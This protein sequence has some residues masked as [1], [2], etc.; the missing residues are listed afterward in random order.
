MGLEEGKHRSIEARGLL[1][2]PPRFEAKGDVPLRFDTVAHKEKGLPSPVFANRGNVGG[3][4]LK[5]WKVVFSNKQGV[6]TLCGSRATRFQHPRPKEKS[7]FRRRW[8]TEFRVT[9]I[10]AFGRAYDRQQ[11]ANKPACTIARFALLEWVVGT[12]E[13]KAS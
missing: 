11:K 8:V 10:E 12:F 2:N 9:Q 4:V 5:T 6:P 13:I 3:N 1:Q 7:R